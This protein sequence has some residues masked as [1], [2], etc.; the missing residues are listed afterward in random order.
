MAAAGATWWLDALLTRRVDNGSDHAVRLAAILTYVG[1]NGPDT[2]ARALGLTALVM[3]WASVALGLWPAAGPVVRALHRQTGL[4]TLALVA[5][6]ATVPFTA[7]YAPYGGWR[8]NL[9]P[10]AQPVSWGIQAAAWESFG[11]LA[12]YLLLL[13][14]PTYWLV[15][16]R[17]R[18]WVA[19]HRAAAAVYGLSVA[20][21]VLLGSDFIVRG[22]A[23]VALLAA[24]VPLLVLAALRLGGRPAGRP[25]LVRRL[26]TL[27]TAAAGVGAVLMTVLT[28]LVATGAYAPGMRL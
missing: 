27:G 15:R 4:V 19:V 12:F 1:V 16:R 10:F 14:G 5:A 21:A 9:V 26:S 6:H 17:R 8:T 28:V 24:Q 2:L 18:A 3:A 25:D 11:I 7:V 23:R 22:P 13:T 20:H